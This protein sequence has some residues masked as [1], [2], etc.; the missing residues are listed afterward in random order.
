MAK[1]FMVL[2][3]IFCFISTADAKDSRFGEGTEIV[4]EF[5]KANATCFLYPNNQYKCACSQLKNPKKEIWTSQPNDKFT[6]QLSVG[7]QYIFAQ[8]CKN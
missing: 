3:L 4:N 2:A 5:Q 7:M 8:R 1:F 6:G